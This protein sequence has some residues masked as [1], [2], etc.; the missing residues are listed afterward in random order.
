MMEIFNQIVF[1]SLK[2]EF[3]MCRTTQGKCNLWKNQHT[4]RAKEEKN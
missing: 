3:K 1:F 2:K 4:D